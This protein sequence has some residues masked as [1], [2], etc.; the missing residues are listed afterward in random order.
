MSIRRAQNAA[1]CLILAR[2]LGLR[3]SETLVRHLRIQRVL[4]ESNDLLEAADAKRL[5]DAAVASMEQDAN[6]SAAAEKHLRIFKRKVPWSTIANGRA[7]FA[8]WAQSREG[9]AAG[10]AFS[11]RTWKL[12]RQLN[13]YTGAF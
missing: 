10:K 11:S 3:S 9:L 5:Y 8:D 2:L 6:A 12:I 1:R 13:D 7:D 4:D